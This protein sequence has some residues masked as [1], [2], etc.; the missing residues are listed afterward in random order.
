MK[1]DVTPPQRR[2]STLR[3]IK[4]TSLSDQVVEH[5]L[6]YIQREFKPGD[7]L[8]S[9]KMLA[10]RLGVGRS[11]LREALRSLEVIG[12][13]DIRN[14]KGIFVPQDPARFL[15]KPL[16][17]GLFDTGKSIR[18][19]TEAR[20]ILEMGILDLV[21]E[22]ITESDLHELNRIVERMEGTSPADRARFI[23]DDLSFHRILVEATRNSVLNDLMKITRSILRRERIRALETRTQ[24]RFAA[25]QH[26][27]VLNGL[28]RRDA[29]ATRRAMAAHMQRQKRLFVGPNTKQGAHP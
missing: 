3:P 17:W 10:E 12:L 8:P 29:K 23:E 13:V 18:E 16:D 25:A 28:C 19:L 24:I 5:L 1:H 22:R 7:G 11:S 21:L 4:S 27:A 26:R 15:Q 20:T 14:G 6:A 9:E 2:L